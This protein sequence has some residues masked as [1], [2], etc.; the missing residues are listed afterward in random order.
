MRG[1]AIILTESRK[2]INQLKKIADKNKSLFDFSIENGGELIKKFNVEDHYDSISMQKRDILVQLFIFDFKKNLKDRES[3]LTKSLGLS[4]K[5]Y[6]YN[7]FNDGGTK[8]DPA[9]KTTTKNWQIC[10]LNKK[11]DLYVYYKLSLDVENKEIRYII[12]QRERS[13]FNNVKVR[14][15]FFN[16]VSK[17]NIKKLTDEIF[18]DI[19]ENHKFK[20]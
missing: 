15:S 7:K 6:L 3:E 10:K 16:G 14:E 13:T 9:S 2:Y 5:P 1:S 20:I 18:K 11:D 4:R 17:E 8:Y 12:E 19:I